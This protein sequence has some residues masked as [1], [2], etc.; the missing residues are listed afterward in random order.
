MQ[1]HL[2]KEALVGKLAKKA[3]HNNNNMEDI[4]KRVV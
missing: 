2:G 1:P 4:K 3:L